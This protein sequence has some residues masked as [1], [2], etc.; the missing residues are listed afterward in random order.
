MAD[1]TFVRA[2]DGYFYGY[3]TENVWNGKA[4]RKV[5][6]SRSK[7]MIKWEYIGDAFTHMPEWKH[8]GA[9]WAPQIVYRPDHRMYYLYYAFCGGRFPCGV[10]VAR[11]EQAY[12]PFEDMGKIFDESTCNLSGSIDPFYIETGPPSNRTAYLFTGSFHGIYGWKMDSDMKTRIGDKFKIIGNGFEGSF[13]LEKDGNFFFFGSSGNCCV[14]KKSN[15]HISVA[16]ATSITG[17]YLRKD[18]VSIMNDDTEGTAFLFG[19]LSV[20]WIGPGHNGEIIKDDLGR[21]FIV[22]HAINP[23]LPKFPDGQPSMMTRRPA[24][25]DEVLWDADGW[26]YIEEGVPSHRYKRAPVFST[27]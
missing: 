6:I 7:D 25:M 27:T 1:P 8:N 9:V 11:S 19:N 2:H 4:D 23:D 12:G 5:A 17:P 15:Y 3:G 13:I 14:G 18:G 16:R 20:G 26:P 24:L 10:G 21:Y 22:Y